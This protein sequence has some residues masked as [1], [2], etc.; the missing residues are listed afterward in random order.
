MYIYVNKVKHY[1]IL[2]KDSSL[3]MTVYLK[4]DLKLRTISQDTFKQY[5]LI[6]DK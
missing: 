1:F 5:V 6:E 4:E 3:L 2:S